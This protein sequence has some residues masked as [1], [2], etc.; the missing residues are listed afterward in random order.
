M[1]VLRI[2]VLGQNWAT[3]GLALAK[4]LALP[5]MISAAMAYRGAP[6]SVHD[7]IYIFGNADEAYV[8]LLPHSTEE[9]SPSVTT[10]YIER[11]VHLHPPWVVSSVFPINDGYYCAIMDEN[12]F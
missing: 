3:K 2:D 10:A 9:F 11:R 4:T 12:V 1:I 7:R 5:V 6:P 8:E